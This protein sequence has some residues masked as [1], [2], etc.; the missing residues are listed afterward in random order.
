MPPL[1]IPLLSPLL[2]CLLPSFPTTPWHCL[3]I[4]ADLLERLAFFDFVQEMQLFVEKVLQLE[5]QRIELRL[6]LKSEPSEMKWECE[7]GNAMPRAYRGTKGNE[8]K[9]ER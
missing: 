3:Q 7:M 5:V 9:R 1:R 4:A 6:A 2:T 8:T